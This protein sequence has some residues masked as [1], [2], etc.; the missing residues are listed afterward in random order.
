MLVR[1]L[2]QVS[3]ISLAPEVAPESQIPPKYNDSPGSDGTD[4]VWIGSHLTAF[5][6]VRSTLDGFHRL[7]RADRHYDM[8]YRAV[9]G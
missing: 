1:L 7:T 5:A 2:Q 9:Y 3:A 8:L 6:K 4:R